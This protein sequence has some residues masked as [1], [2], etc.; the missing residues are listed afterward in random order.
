ML[1]AP[2]N[3]TF[4]A[5]PLVASGLTGARS[6]TVAV[7]V[8]GPIGTIQ[9][10]PGVALQLQVQGPNGP[11]A[12]ANLN[13]LDPVTG[14]AAVLVGDHA[15]AAGRIVCLAP[16]GLCTLQLR[17]A[18]GSLSA[19]L[20]IPNCP[21]L[22]PASATVTLPPKR[23]CVDLRGFGI[24]ATANS[25]SI[26]FIPTL[27]NPQAVEQ[28]M[29]LDVFVKLSTGVESPIFSGIPLTL[30]AG[31]TLPGSVSFLPVGNLPA[32][33]LGKVLRYTIRVRSPMDNSVL[34]EAFADFAA[35]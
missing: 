1:L 23:A 34:D 15:D 7:T 25:G 22:F 30:P 28:P 19:P 12:G 3:Y 20:S 29:L 26:P 16:P 8:G 35:Y 21:I 11:E 18:Q 6:G 9:V 2:G 32:S 33:E 4:T 14:E 17:G 13:L 10:Q 31:L 27:A 5:Q 24:Q